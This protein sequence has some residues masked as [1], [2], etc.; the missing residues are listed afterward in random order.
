MFFFWGGGIA[1]EG[2]KRHRKQNPQKIPGQSR[3]N[4]A[5]SVFF[6]S[7]VCL[8][9]PSWVTSLNPQEVSRVSKSVLPRRFE[10]LG[11]S[12]M[13]LQILCTAQRECTLPCIAKLLQTELNR[14]RT[15]RKNIKMLGGRCPGQNRNLPREKRDP[16]LRE[17]NRLGVL[18]TRG[19]WSHFPGKVPYCVQITYGIS[20]HWRK[21]KQCRGAPCLCRTCNRARL[22]LINQVRGLK[23]GLWIRGRWICV[24]GAPDF[25]PKS[26]WN[27]S[28]SGF[29]GLWTENQGAPTSRFNDHG[30]NAPVS[31]LWLSWV[32]KK[33]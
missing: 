29:G 23:M 14:A 1:Y 19:G 24:W 11:P 32:R 13:T 2:E 4:S 22:T 28:K 16:C 17:G 12:G 20:L 10:H 25:C 15:K 9:L 21:L 31:A 30:S 26:L 6:A 33:N 18:E 3:K 8:S 5:F 7:E 27:P